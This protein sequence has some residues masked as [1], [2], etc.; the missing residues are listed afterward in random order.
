MQHSV[1]EIGIRYEDLSRLRNETVLFLS[2][3]FLSFARENRDKYNL[4]DNGE[5]LL[6]STW[7]VDQL[8]SDFKN[9][10]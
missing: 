8:L 9:K 2:S 6:V 7:H 3:V 5:D 1:K 10:L 4:V